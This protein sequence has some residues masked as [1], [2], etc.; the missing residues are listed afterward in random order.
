M[1]KLHKAFVH[2]D[3]DHGENCTFGVK[4]PFADVY[5][6]KTFQLLLLERKF[7]EANPILHQTGPLIE[8]WVQQNSHQKESVAKQQK[9]Y[10]QMF[11]LVLQARNDYSTPKD[12]EPYLFC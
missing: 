4:K 7:A 6:L 3:Q 11:F 8:S 12:Q 5:F 9:E 10:L 2:V 1:Q